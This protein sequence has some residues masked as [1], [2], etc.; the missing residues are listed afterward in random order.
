MRSPGAGGVP[1]AGSPE[2]FAA[3]VANDV[4]VWEEDAKRSG[5]KTD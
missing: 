2:E 5:I 1:W 3:F 4:P